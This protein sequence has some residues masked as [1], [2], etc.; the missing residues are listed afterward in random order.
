MNMVSF[1]E[2]G[3]NCLNSQAGVCLSWCASVPLTLKPGAAS[4]V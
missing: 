2:A 4:P 3:P 1:L